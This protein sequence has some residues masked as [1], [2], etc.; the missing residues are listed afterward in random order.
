MSI[1]NTLISGQLLHKNPLELLKL[2][3][4]VYQQKTLERLIYQASETVLGREY[5]FNRLLLQEDLMDAYRKSVPF[6]DYD[7]MYERWWS[8]CLAGEP[9]VSWPGMVPYFAL[10][11]G[12]TGAPSKF[13]PVTKPMIRSIQKGGTRCIL[14][15]RRFGVGLDFYTRKLML[16]GG[17][18]SLQDMGAYQVGDLSGINIGN[19]P[20]WIKL[21]SK[22]DPEIASIPDWDERLEEIARNANKWDIGSLTGS[23]AWNRLMIKRIIEVNKVDTIHDVWPNLCAFAHGGVSFEPYRK[24]FE[25]L[26][27]R[28]IAYIDTYLASEGF[29]AYQ[30]RPE[31]NSMALI[32]NNGMYFEF[33]PFDDEHFDSEGNLIGQPKALH[34]GEVALG[35]DYA[36][37]VTTC[38]GAWRYLIGDT[39]RFTDLA[40]AEITITGR[41][42]HFLSVCGEHLSVGNMSE[43]I[44]KIQEELGAE[45]P[46]FGVSAHAEGDRFVHTWYVGANKQLDSEL[47]RQKLDM[48]LDAINDDY[49]VERK[50]LLDVV[51]KQVPLKLFYG[52]LE[53]IGKIGGQHKFPRVLK[54]KQLEAW[55]SWLNSQ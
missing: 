45:I 52:W 16:L 12:T 22:P 50:A 18:T 3:P 37:V 14:A 4:E 24:S 7:S 30:A 29:V 2:R 32:L 5:G 48:H 34:I 55:L 54:G 40:R 6:A 33:I 35:V 31:T 9:D 38:A 19:T 51:V 27:Q 25:S 26:M 44:C 41:T 10:S 49:R 8:R 28:P 15:A 21:T 36:L 42:K 47:I 17:T 23:P 43:A 46:E 20:F 11:S 53:Q 39:I 1:L 13:I